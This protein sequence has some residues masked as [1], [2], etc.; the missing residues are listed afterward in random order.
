MI[1]L[2]SDYLLWEFLHEKHLKTSQKYKNLSTPFR[3][4]VEDPKKKTISNDLSY[5]GW[6]AEA[7]KDASKNGPGRSRKTP[8]K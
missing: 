4:T 2:L 3:P 1:M 7:A 6:C 5:A 8:R